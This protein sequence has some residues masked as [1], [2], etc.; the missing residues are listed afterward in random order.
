MRPEEVTL[1]LVCPQQ[2]FKI[3]LLIGRMHAALRGQATLIDTMNPAIH[4]SA[5]FIHFRFA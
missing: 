3:E 2:I 5:A 1:T 4:Y